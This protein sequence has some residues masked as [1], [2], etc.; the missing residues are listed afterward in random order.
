MREELYVDCYES[1]TGGHERFRQSHNQYKAA[2]EKLYRYILRFQATVYC[3]YT[4]MSALRFAQDSIKWH[5]WEQLVNELRD[6]ES[7]FTAIEEKWRD[8]QRRE[9]HLAVKN[10]QQTTNNT[11]SAQLFVSQKAFDSATEKE[12][13]ELLHWLCDV[14]PSAMHNAARDRHETGTN[15]WLISDSEEFKAWE[16]GDRSLLWLHGKGMLE[17]SSKLIYLP[18]ILTNY[19]SIAGSGKSI[20]TSSVITYLR[21]QYASK[22]SLSTAL[23]YFYFSFSDPQKQ[24]VDVMLASLIKQICSYF[25]GELLFR[26]AF[27]GH[28]KRGERP[29]TQTLEKMLVTSASSFSNVYVVIDALDECPLLNDQREKLLKSLGRIVIDAP[30]NVH[31]FLTSRKEQDIDKRLRAFLSL[32]SRMEIDLLAHQEMLNRDIHH[33]IDLKLATDAFH[34][35]P[36]SVKEEVKQSLVEKAD[37]MLV[38]IRSVLYQ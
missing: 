34:S 38:F 29:D 33:Y 15:E 20:L 13:E 26:E 27:R 5:S 37:C 7:N 1:G 17:F 30:K 12:Y 6:Q 23:A 24:K 31:I 36:E 3:Y 22:S 11:L 35:W 32:P 10:R 19:L 8:I 18:K 14:D 16:T 21:D 25:S 4:N 28:K 9:E 2:L